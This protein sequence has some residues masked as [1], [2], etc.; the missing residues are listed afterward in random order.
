MCKGMYDVQYLLIN[1]LVNISV[2]IMHMDL[3][4]D[5]KYLKTGSTKAQRLKVL[6]EVTLTAI[7]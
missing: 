3:L 2:T 1:H 5:S 4:R 7:A 6:A